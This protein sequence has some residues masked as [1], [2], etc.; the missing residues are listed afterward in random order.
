MNLILFLGTMIIAFIAVRIGAVAF[1]LTG[2]EWSLAKFQAISCFTGTGFTTKESELIASN[3][4][5]RRIAS[6][7]M[8]LGNIGLVTL[9][10]TFANSLRPTM[11]LT[12][13]FLKTV[14][15]AGLLPW[16]NF[17]LIIVLS[18]LIYRLFTHTKFSR[19][20]TN[21][22]RQ[23]I[24]K[25]DIVTKVSFE[26]LVVATGGYGISNI[27]IIENTPILNKSLRETDL[28]I[29]DISVLAIE[30]ENTIIPN[31]SPDMKII[32]GDKLVCFGKLDTIKREF[33][34]IE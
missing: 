32:L 2:L 9:I 13:P 6:V 20:L 14:V 27:E 8:V 22:M 3:P 24:I 4:Q 34:V 1:E 12:I 28:R 33:K 29:H 18:Y 17:V 25:K 7:L 15:P 30:K 16:V 31:P 11:T 19:R 5:R 21:R 23:A 10:A 26:E